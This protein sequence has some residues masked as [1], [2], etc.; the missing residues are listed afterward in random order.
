MNEQSI[1]V[2]ADKRWREHISSTPPG[3]AVQGRADPSDTQRE[4]SSKRQSAED[5]GSI[6]RTASLLLKHLVRQGLVSHFKTHTFDLSNH[7]AKDS[8]S[9][10]LVELF[11][12]RL[13]VVEVETTKNMTA[14][15]I[16]KYNE[17]RLVLKELGV[18][19]VMWSDKKTPHSTLALCTHIKNN[20]EELERCSSISIGQE[21]LEQLRSKTR[22]GRLHLST[23]I[24]TTGATW[25]QVVSA[26]AWNHISTSVEEQLHP[27]S[28]FLPPASVSTYQS[29]FLQRP[30]TEGWWQSLPNLDLDARPR[31]SD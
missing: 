21:T 8:C 11:T 14:E 24:D 19:S 10:L 17:R 5:Q 18:D 20:L 30:G 15:L 29:Y 23:L 28:S 22:S 1:D 6:K 2:A 7:G 27:A 16:K 26:W 3:E 31:C 4:L 12:G 9:A 13:V 25:E